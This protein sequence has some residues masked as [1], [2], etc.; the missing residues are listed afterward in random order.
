MVLRFVYRLPLAL[1]CLIG[2]S[3]SGPQISI[4]QVFDQRGLPVEGAVVEVPP[5]A[6]SMRALAFPWRNAMA[7]RN[8]TFVPGTLIV[9]QGS[10]VAFPN[11]DTVRHSIYSF[12]KPARF[13]IDLYG[14][15][16]T[17]SQRFPVLGTVALGCNIHDKMRGYIR[18][19][20]TPYATAT[21]LNGRGQIDGLAPGSYRVTI[22]HPRLRS[23]S[24]ETVQTVTIAPGTPAR[25]T[26]EMR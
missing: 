18:V 21:D 11:L 3:A 1:L 20:A 16:Q 26:I 22:W 24:G 19:V 12:S 23:N 25:V 4:V 5:P 10:S 7:Q 17:R 6:G 2:V 14:R 9:P 13:Q 8:Q 15:D